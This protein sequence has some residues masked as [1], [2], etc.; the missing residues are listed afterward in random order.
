MENAVPQ[1][2]LTDETA[3]IDGKLA[4]VQKLLPHLLLNLDYSVVAKTM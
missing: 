4:E 3:N 2:V 1:G